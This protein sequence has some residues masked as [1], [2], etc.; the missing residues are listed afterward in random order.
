[1]KKF[2]L[3]HSTIG[4]ISFIFVFI[5]IINSLNFAF[6]VDIRTKD[7]IDRKKNQ[8]ILD[9][10]IYQT[11]SFN[12]LNFLNSNGSRNDLIN[13]YIEIEIE[14][15]GKLEKK[16]ASN[17]IHN[18]LNTDKLDEIVKSIKNPAI[19]LKFDGKTESN[20]INDT[21][22]SEIEEFIIK[23]YSQ[24]SFKNIDREMEDLK[25]KKVNAI[26]EIRRE[27]ISSILNNLTKNLN[28][29]RIYLNF[30]ITGIATA[31][32]FS[33]FYLISRYEETRKNRI[34]NF[35][36]KIPIEIYIILFFSI[37]IIIRNLE[38][39]FMYIFNE[40]HNE[41]L[42]NS[43]LNI[44][45]V[46]MIL[47]IV[48]VVFYIV[49]CIKSIYYE[50]INSFI[51][52]NSIIFRLLK[53]IHKI[54]E[55]LLLKVFQN[56]I[57]HLVVWAIIFLVILI[58]GLGLIPSR[59]EFIIF[60]IILSII[61]YIL[62]RIVMDFRKIENATDEI[63]KGN[64]DISLD[65]N[66]LY[67]R[68]ISHNLNNI[69]VILNEAVEKELKSERTKTNLITNVSHDLKTPLTS[70]INYSDLASKNNNSVEDVK[71]YTTIIHEK[72]LKLKKLIDNLFEV[73]KVSSKN[74]EVKK[75]L[76]DINE[77]INQMIGEWHDEFENKKLEVIFN[78]NSDKNELQ[79]DPSHMSRVLDNIFSNINK[80]AKEDTRVYID[81][82]KEDSMKIIIKNI[83]KY[84]LNISPEELKERFTRGDKSRN[85]EGS[86][87]G[88]AIAS[89]LIEIQGGKFELEI[90]G[91][92]F[93]VII[94]I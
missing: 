76:I 17:N 12:S 72:S 22:L 13:Y 89:S 5:L 4:I 35:L 74:I 30:I 16:F 44:L 20:T 59:S 55:Y 53:G 87:L 34:Y 54:F 48:F 18:K 62:T 83:S 94:I 47:S 25:L 77:M 38:T 60:F 81:I 49:S 32:I 10:Y 85:T 11:L 70:I 43:V 69:N 75:I 15:N 21:N 28:I 84:S 19:L 86:G 51:F 3:R 36:I 93:K 73:S 66:K 61:Y 88:L 42:N 33:L 79:M 8:Y 46:I 6:N 37:E 50:G 92:L 29:D 56:S 9:N 7:Y 52:N 14:N 63:R 57:T 39:G 91:D 24:I 31:I 82:I 65:E 80:Y 2:S 45:S 26:Y 27:N 68:K 23:E 40:Y 1:M 67:F 41:A 90:D 71:K 78:S 64:F 58:I